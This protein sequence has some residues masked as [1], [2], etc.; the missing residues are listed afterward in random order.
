[1]R[2]EVRRISGRA[3]AYFREHGLAKTLAR[4]SA[5]L[6]A[7]LG[8]PMQAWLHRNRSFEV[9]GQRYSYFIHHYNATWRNERA[10]EVAMSRA[11]L[12][13]CRKPVLEVGNVLSHYLEIDHEVID[14]YEVA[15]N[16]SNLDVVDLEAIGTYGQILSISTLEHVGWDEIP[17]DPDKVV[18]A[19]AK[20]K[21]ALKEDGELFVSCPLGHNPCLDDLI[22]KGTL[23]PVT[24]Y[25]LSRPSRRRGWI[26][27][28][29]EEWG[30][31][32]GDST[33]SGGPLTLWVARLNRG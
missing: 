17:R 31:P 32:S 1:M 5:K 30:G 29:R 10:V 12:A 16:V 3:R 8:Y 27:I 7:Y 28:S 20:L 23:H 6:R 19:I 24:E 14:K 13:E 9:D 4:T 26:Q 18:V 21:A 11:V 25:F 2:S 15:P 22:H 33:D